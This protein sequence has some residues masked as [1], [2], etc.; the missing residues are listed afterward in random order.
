MISF[1][2]GD[3]GR[4]VARKLDAEGVPHEV[5]WVEDDAPTRTCTTLLSED[6]AV[7]ELVEETSSVSAGDV[8]KL[9][10]AVTGHR[11]EARVLCLIGSLPPGVPGDFYARLTKAVHEA[12]LP[13]FVD[14]KD[15]PSA[16]PLRS[17]P[18]WSS[19]TWKRPPRHWTSR[20]AR[21]TPIPPS[22][23]LLRRALGGHWSPRGQSDLCLVTTPASGGA[24]NPCAS[25]PSTLSAPGTLSRRGSSSTSFGACPFLAP[26][27]T[28]PPAP[29]PTLSPLPPVRSVPT[30]S[31][32][33]FPGYDRR[34]SLKDC[35]A[36]DPGLTGLVAVLANRS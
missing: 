36:E 35:G 7:T 10:S 19:P 9:E 5:V 20:L 26:P 28:A 12:H 15:A 32:L 23:R 11:H 29:P 22:P 13:V 27:S 3:P 8:G 2:G 6:G 33:C 18:S 21:S 1:L 17:T 30:T 16:P 24:S 31:L 34:G 4:F 25:R 14:A